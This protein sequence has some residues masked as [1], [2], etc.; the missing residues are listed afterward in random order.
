MP[1]HG[2]RS[3][4]LTMMSERMLRLTRAPPPDNHSRQ[5]IGHI[6]TLSETKRFAAKIRLSKT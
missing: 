2:Y 4:G 5:D 1:Q 6:G 3:D